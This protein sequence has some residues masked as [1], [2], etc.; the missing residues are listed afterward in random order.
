MFAERFDL[1][2]RTLEETSA[3]FHYGR[4]DWKGIV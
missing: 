1:N 2:G 4:N 3:T